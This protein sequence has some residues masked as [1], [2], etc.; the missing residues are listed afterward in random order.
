MSSSEKDAQNAGWTLFTLV[1]DRSGSMA[2]IKRHMER[3]IKALI[4]EQ[5]DGEGTCVVTLTQFDD[6]YEVVADGVPAADMPPYEL[7]PRNGT[8]LLDAIGRTIALVHARIESMGPADR[9][10][11]VVVAVITDGHENASQQ[12]SRVQVMDAIKAKTAEGWHFTFLGADEDALREGLALGFPVD[13]LLLWERSDTGTASAMQSLSDSSRRLRSGAATRIDYTEAERQAASGQLI[14]PLSLR[15][16]VRPYLFLD[17]DGVLN[18]SQKDLGGNAD[19][20]DDFVTHDVDF[21]VVAGYHRSVAVRLSPAMG[22]RVARLAVDTQWVTTWG[23]RANSAIAPPCGL[24]RDLPVLVQGDNDEEWDLDWK[25]RAVRQ[26]VEADPR[27]FV[28]I[29]D[30]IDFLRDEAVSPR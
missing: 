29:D 21:D 16:S 6:E 20:F 12:W 4:E 18:V 28:W 24:P 9:P 3:A 10:A 25:F 22:A 2:R 15:R 14:G 17:I 1:V 13:T 26:V 27:P 23:H 8:A 19:I 11:T 7:D 5:A 30:D